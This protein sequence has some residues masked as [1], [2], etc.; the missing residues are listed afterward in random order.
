M[1]FDDN[2]FFIYVMPISGGYICAHLGL[3][4]E[5]YD[6]RILAACGNKNGYYSYAPH[7]VFGSSG[8]NV[9]AFI[10]Q[11]SD[12]TSHGISRNVLY[13]NSNLFLKKWV[14]EKL[15]ILPE[16]PFFFLT[17]SI[18]NKGY[19]AETLFKRLFTPKSIQ[20]SEMWLGT[21]DINH[22]K[23]QFFCNRSQDSSYITEPFFN[24][25]QSLYYAMPLN[26]TDGNI[27]K[28]AKVCIASATIPM[29]VPPQEI[30][31][32]FYSDG[33]VM[34]SS[35][36]SVFHKEVIHIITGKEKSSTIKCFQPEV[37]C[38]SNYEFV[39]SECN[40]PCE[41]NLRLF[42]FFPYQPNGLKYGCCN[43][44]LSIKV[45]LDSILNVS[46]MNDRNAAIEIIKTL[47]PEGIKTKTYLSINTYELS[48]IIKEL[49]CK[50]H[51]MICLYPHRNPSIDITCINGPKMLKAMEIVKKG[52]GCQIWYSNANK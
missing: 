23:A 26:F 15:S 41:K 35:P 9:S 52:Y 32:N 2:D 25:E 50:K 5:V 27:E 36:L 14:P 24:E 4:S 34:Y 11:A 39:Y 40:E 6:A 18:Y 20:K 1:C 28:L 38:A 17:G 8:G 51:Y 47:S 49:S 42:Y 7:L 13:M 37:D 19:G 21:Y 44:T 30:D 12:W 22:K 33:G 10:G 31:G 16:I 46:M 45:Y 3:L 29:T 43:E 48:K